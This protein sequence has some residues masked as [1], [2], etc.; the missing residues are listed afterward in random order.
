[1][2]RLIQ[3]KMTRQFVR[4]TECWTTNKT[5]ASHFPSITD[6][7]NYC[8]KHAL[9][10]VHV[11]CFVEGASVHPFVLD[12]VPRCQYLRNESGGH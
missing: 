8:L 2:T 9:H 11:Y 10:D 5:E 6:A 3:H 12:V 4:T 7:V 1:M